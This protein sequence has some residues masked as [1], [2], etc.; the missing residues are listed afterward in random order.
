MILTLS[1]YAALA[2]LP[3]AAW[4]CARLLP[5]R[6]NAPTGR[7]AIDGAGD[8]LSPRTHKAPAGARALKRLSVASRCEGEFDRLEN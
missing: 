6:K 3:P 7:A 2:I 8:P 5:L 1:V 4:V